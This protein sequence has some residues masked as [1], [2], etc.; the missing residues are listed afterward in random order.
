MKRF[1][2]SVENWTFEFGAT[3]GSFTF[4]LNKIY[5]MK[6]AADYRTLGVDGETESCEGGVECTRELVNGN[7]LICT[8]CL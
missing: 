7:A 4:E 3:S 8:E 5:L 2:N 1:P 6:G